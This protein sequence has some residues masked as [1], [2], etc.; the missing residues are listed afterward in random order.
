M[1]RLNRIIRYIVAALM[2]LLASGGMLGG[3]FGNGGTLAHV[4][5]LGT[6]LIFLATSAWILPLRNSSMPQI[7]EPA[8]FSHSYWF[9]VAICFA[10]VIAIAIVLWTLGPLMEMILLDSGLI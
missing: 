8:A 3:V 6:G 1:K 7:V 10:C 4:L 2:M 5:R 9:R